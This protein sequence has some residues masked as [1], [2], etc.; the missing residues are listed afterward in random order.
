MNSVN[1]ISILADVDV[2]ADTTGMQQQLQQAL[3]Q[4]TSMAAG[5]ED[6]QGAA[7]RLNSTLEQIQTNARKGY[8]KKQTGGTDELLGELRRAAADVDQL[9]REQIEGLKTKVGEQAGQLGANATKA[10]LKHLSDLEVSV[11]ITR[12]EVDP[13]AARRAK[14]KVQGAVGDVTTHVHVRV[15]QRSV[16]AAEAQIDAIESRATAAGYKARKLAEA[17]AKRVSDLQARTRR[18]MAVQDARGGFENLSARDIAQR[19]GGVRLRT[20]SFAAFE[21]GMEETR[22]RGLYAQ[23]AQI[24]QERSDRRERNRLIWRRAR[25]VAEERQ[26]T[27]NRGA[28]D[29]EAVARDT[30]ALRRRFDETGSFGDSGMVAQLMTNRTRRLT[31]TREAR[32]LT[33][34][35]GQ[36]ERAA[37]GESDELVREELLA[38]ADR[39]RGQAQERRAEFQGQGYWDRAGLLVDRAYGKAQPVPWSPAL[40]TGIA[41]VA[42][43]AVR[44]REDAANERA[45]VQ[46]QVVAPAILARQ[47]QDAGRVQTRVEQDPTRRRAQAPRIVGRARRFT[48]APATSMFSP[49][50]MG[51]EYVYRDGAQPGEYDYHVPQTS[52]LSAAGEASLERAAQNFAASGATPNAYR[53]QAIKGPAQLSYWRPKNRQSLANAL[54]NPRGLLGWLN[55]ARN[56]PRQDY[57]RA[58]FGQRLLERLGVTLSYGDSVA[59]IPVQPGTRLHDELRKQKAHSESDPSKPIIAGGNISGSQ[60]KHE[61][62]NALNPYWDNPAEALRL[63]YGGYEH[64]PEGK[65]APQWVPGGLDSQTLFLDEP[66]GIGATQA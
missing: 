5:L 62:A 46:A 44:R 58:Y 49:E 33:L 28:L 14:E 10:L 18:N 42:A 50:H 26:L 4:D 64:D 13:V 40:R 63:I 38:R 31:A 45:R 7:S 51:V 34:R 2:V 66:G 8:F 30:R 16:A 57:D 60:V 22:S 35:A 20:G 56:A 37:A 17:E 27:E 25:A 1:R 47:A 9:S 61:L 23:R 3:P 65:E 29:P 19:G 52:R 11:R 41:A 6:A 55:A 32:E 48:E 24:T 54:G 59:Q 53:Y 15:D 21:R 36:A 39:A 43:G 12:V